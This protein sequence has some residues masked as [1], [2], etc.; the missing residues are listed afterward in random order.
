VLCKQEGIWFHVD[1]AFGALAF[2]SPALKSRLCGLEKADSIAFDFHKWMHVPYDAGCILVRNGEMHRQTFTTRRSYLASATRGAASGDPWFC[3][4]GPELSRSFRALKVWFT[5]KEHGVERLAGMIEKNC[6]QAEYLGVA[7]RKHP[8]L[9]LLAPISLNIVCFRYV[10]ATK[11]DLDLNDINAEI[12]M[13]MHEKGLAVPSTTRLNGAL[14]IRVN[15][16]N[17]R[18]QL[19][20]LDSLLTDI[21]EI[22]DSLCTP[23]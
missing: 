22:G 1:G 9:Q 19:G 13:T 11:Q 8:Q 18:C 3:E 12:V 14:A 2:M 20:D 16:T 17:H 4:Y 21:V 10:P 5:I 6:R 7:V 15:L 23:K